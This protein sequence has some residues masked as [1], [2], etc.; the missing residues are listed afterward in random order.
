MDRI[1]MAKVSNFQV[2]QCDEVCVRFAALPTFA[3]LNE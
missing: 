2:D 3:P 1:L